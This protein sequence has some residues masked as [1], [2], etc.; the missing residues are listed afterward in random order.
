M[1]K[2]AA[3]AIFNALAAA[4]FGAGTCTYTLG[5]LGPTALYKMT[6]TCTGDASTGSFPSTTVSNVQT[7][8]IQGYHVQTVLFLPGSTAPTNGYAATVVNSVSVDYLSG[9]ASSL[10]S[11]T[12]NQYGMTASS[13]PID[14]TVTLAITGNSVAS[15][16]VTVVLYL[17]PAS[18][19]RQGSSSGGGSSGVSSFNTRTG[20]VTLGSGDVDTAL[21]F[22]PLANPM[23]TTD[24]L[25]GSA[26]NSGG[27]A[28]AVGLVSCANDGSH[29]LVYSTGTH[30]FACASISGSGITA[31]YPLS[32]SGS[33]LSLLYSNDFGLNGSNQLDI[34]SSKWLSIA[35]DQSGA[36]IYCHSTNGTS[37]F[38]CSFS[39]AAA[40]TA[41][42]SG[43][44][45]TLYVDTTCSSSCTLNIDGVGAVNIKKADGS[46][47]PGG[48]LIANRP[49]LVFYNGTTMAMLNGT[50]GVFPGGITTGSS[51]PAITPGTGGVSGFNL[52]TNPSAGCPGAGVACIVG[53]LANE[54]IELSN[55]ND[56]LQP[57]ERGPTLTTSGHLVSYNGSGASGPV[58]QD[59]GIASSS[60]ALNCTTTITT[61]ATATLSTCF[62]VNEEAT[63]S[64]AITYTLPTA[65]SGAQ[66]CIDNGYNGSA[67]NT[68]TL[69][70]LTSASGQY[71]VYTDGTLSAS[72]GYIISAGAA[73]DGACVYGIDSTHW[74]F[75]PHAGSWTKH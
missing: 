64:T 74:M 21:G 73:R 71:L 72:G 46:T 17:A 12:P 24:Q 60:V 18:Y 50:D 20:A 13:P 65:S 58:T 28:A 29:A 62:T 36:A 48:V 75:L 45:V 37:G 43:M 68:G 49:Y 42:T 1:K 51:P 39:S 23:T 14:N 47:D 7:S 10:S 56:S 63:A 52:G 53:N 66:Y 3:I 31:S 54:T 2:W 5:P 38:G 9:Q 70:L 59:S 55:N 19:A 6:F 35:A 26:G 44:W 34:S 16:N 57:I 25:I 32:L 11:T 40:L 61:G 4:A 67:A 8:V 33:V 15:A 41:Y 30:S 22:T 27:T 69:E